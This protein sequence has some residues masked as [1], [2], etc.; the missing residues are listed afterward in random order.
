MLPTSAGLRAAAIALLIFSSVIVS[1][2]AAAADKEVC[3]VPADFALGLEDYST[4]ITLHRRLLSSHPD[5]ALAH[6]PFGFCLW[7]GRAR[8]ARNQ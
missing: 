5:D 3:D 8:P 6:L 4:T 1:S 7:H 2:G